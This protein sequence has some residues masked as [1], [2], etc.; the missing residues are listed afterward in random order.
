MVHRIPTVLFALALAT[1]AIAAAPVPDDFAFGVEV[2]L[3]GDSALWQLE[4]PDDVYRTVTRPD[5][6]DLRVFNGAGEVVPHSLQRPEAPRTV[7]GE[8]APLPFFALRPRDPDE[9]RGT[10]LRVV[11][12]EQGAVVDVISEAVSGGG[13]ESDRVGAWLIDASGLDQALSKLV[14]DWDRP[15]AADFAITVEVESSEDLVNWQTLVRAT[16]ADLRSGD[17]ALVHRDIPLPYLKAKYLRLS[18]PEAVQT[19]RLSGVR[20]AFGAVQQPLP[21]RWQDIVGAPAAQDPGAFEFDAGG[22]W[23]VDR[24]RL[25]FP[26]GN[27]VVQGVIESRFAAEAPWRTQGR[28]VFYQLRQDQLELRSEPLVLQ[29]GGANHR[30]WRLHAAAGEIRGGMPILELGWLP[31]RLTFV[32]Q[33]PSPYTLAYGSAS[34]GA[35]SESVSA[36]LGDMEGERRAALVKTAELGSL[37]TLGGVARLAP[38]PPPLPVRQWVLWAVLLLGVT[39]LA[40]MVRGSYRQLRTE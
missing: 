11:T 38:P 2:E 13:E 30:H 35:P 4:L 14:L 7:P 26:V 39:V 9:R 1:P 8:P 34:V 19:V 22:Y 12:D 27:A 37:V 33:G 28:G 40:W 31:H 20:A 18:W 25:S 23:P 6:G 10:A 29:P 17:S 24:V 32:A 5:L 16:L 36:L 21:R 15:E 3:E